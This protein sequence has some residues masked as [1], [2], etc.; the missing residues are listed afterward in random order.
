MPT[1]K[2]TTAVEAKKIIQEHNSS[3]KTIEVLGQGSKRTIGRCIDCYNQLDLSGLTGVNFY[4]QSEMVVSAKAGTPVSEITKVLAEGGQ[5]LAFDPPS[6]AA[7]LGSSAEPSI[8][9]VLATNLSGPSRLSKGAARD[10]FLGVEMINGRGEQIKNGGRVMK[11]VTG[12]DLCKLMAG[13]WGTLAAMTDVTLKTLPIQESRVTLFAS[14]LS[15]ESAVQFMSVALGSPFDVVTAAHVPGRSQTAVQIEGLEKSVAYRIEELKLALASFGELET[16]GNEEGDAFWVEVREVNSLLSKK[17]IVWK[18]STTLTA[19]PAL[20][21]E[22]KKQGDVAAFYDWGGGLV[23]IGLDEN[24]SGLDIRAA[25]A[26]VGGQALLFKAPED[27]RKRLDVFDPL[28]PGNRMLSEG[29]KRAFD[30]KAVLNPGRQ[31]E[32]I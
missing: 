24:Q 2:A 12:Y 15:D 1:V 16:I 3:G 9:G 10:H 14:G 5:R 6:Y 25:L 8:G 27:I 20:V 29:V 28:A 11:N 13:S 26:L 22:L 7:L 4:E 17:D 30:P 21:N 23:W 31:F 18:V 19:G 32:G